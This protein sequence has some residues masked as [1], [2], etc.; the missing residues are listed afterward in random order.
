M[1]SLGAANEVSHITPRHMEAAALYNP[2]CFGD[3]AG[4]AAKQDVCRDVRAVLGEKEARRG[5][6]AAD[7]GRAAL[8]GDEG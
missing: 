6:A 2:A 8:C 3:T 5:S 4:T 7:L 1:S